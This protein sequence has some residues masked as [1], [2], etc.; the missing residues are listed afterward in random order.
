VPEYPLPLLPLIL[1]DVPPGLVQALGQEGVPFLHRVSAATRGRFVLFD[2][3]RRA[4]PRVGPGQ[5][6]IDVDRLRDGSRPDPLEALL[7]ERSQRHQWRIGGLTVT[8]EIARVDRRILRKRILG[9]LREAI[10]R[11]GGVWLAVAAFPFPYRSAL[12]FRIDYDQYNPQDF[13]ATL[14][15]IAGHEHATSHF[16]NAAAYLPLEDALARLRGLDVGSHGYRH[17]TYL[18]EEE[19]LTNIRRGIETLRALGIEPSGFVAPHGR[20]N[21][22]LLA[23]MEKSGIGHSSEF[24]LAY[25]D[26][27]FFPRGGSVLQ[28]PIHPVSLGIFLEAA[29]REAA[30]S[31]NTIRQAVHTAVDYFRHTAR[32]KY[33]AGQ[34]VFLYGHPTRRLGSHPEVLRAVFDEAEGFA[35]IWKTTL[36]RF[37]A[38]WRARAGVRLSVVRQADQLVVT[39]NRR[40]DKY[41]LGI[42]FWRGRHVARMPLGRRVLRFSPSALA[43]ENRAAESTVRPVRIDSPEGLRGRIRRWI[44]WE[45]ETPTEEIGSG[46][47]RNWAKRTL[48]RFRN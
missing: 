12:N 31:R 30:R 11:A 38:W 3:R 29:Q 2:S 45:R 39:A 32:G 41:A 8:E 22:G 10:E 5:V 35:A 15:A 17:H 1:E 33:R 25:D 27:P 34:P 44:D 42:E 47:W 26:L 36:S 18:G 43:Y 37:A 7:E 23:A 13:D 4:S 20:F 46:A 40:P 24:G 48:R 21:R 14:G 6:A 19:N 16:V 9:V 28:I